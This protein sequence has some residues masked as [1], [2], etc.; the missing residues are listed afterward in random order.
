MIRTKIK[1]SKFRNWVALS[2][3]LGYSEKNKS[4]LKQ[5]IQR[6]V[7]FL[8]STLKHLNLKVA[9]NA[10]NSLKKEYGFG[11]N[12]NLLSVFYGKN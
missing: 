10:L 11:F 5:R 12:S 6:N 1:Q 2:Q 7:D 4:G 8:N 9:T 3:Y